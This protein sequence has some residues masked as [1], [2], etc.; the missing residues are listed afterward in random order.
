M[1]RNDDSADPDPFRPARP[2]DRLPPPNEAGEVQ[3]RS[4]KWAHLPPVRVGWIADATQEILGATGRLHVFA[5]DGLRRVG[6]R[7]AGESLMEVADWIAARCIA[8]VYLADGDGTG[9]SRVFDLVRPVNPLPLSHDAGEDEGEDMAHRV[10]PPGSGLRSVR[11]RSG[12]PGPGPSQLQALRGSDPDG[13]AAARP[14]AEGEPQALDP[15][16]RDGGARGRRGPPLEEGGLWAAGSGAAHG[17]YAGGFGRSGGWRAG[18]G[19]I[20]TGP[21][22]GVHGQPRIG[23]PQSA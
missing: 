4:A 14:R 5:A 11:R 7:K 22:G 2:P 21:A 1:T 3:R 19:G 17:D 13:A 16:W 9:G 8:M 18:Q 20:A 12:V 23:A 10:H 15:S 6:A